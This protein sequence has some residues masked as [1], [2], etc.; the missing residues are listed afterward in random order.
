MMLTFSIIVRMLQYSFTISLGFPS[1]LGL[2]VAS[3]IALTFL[4]RY[5]YLARYT[6]LKEPALPPPSPPLLTNHLSPL[7]TVGLSDNRHRSS[8]YHNYLDDFLSAIRIFGYLEK[9]VFHEL[10]RHLQ[11]RILAAG[12]TLEIGGGDFWC[13]VEGKVQV[14]SYICSLPYLLSSVSQFAPS[15]D[16][17][18]S[19]PPSPDPF[20]ASES[21]SFNGYHL[22]NEVSTGGTLS[23]LFSILS[24][25][26]EDIKLAWSPLDEEA[27]KEED[28]RA[29][30][31]MTANS[32]DSDLLSA[33]SSRNKARADSDVSQ[34]G[35]DMM[36]RRRVA[37]PDTM[38]YASEE[39]VRLRSSSANTRQSTLRQDS[40]SPPRETTARDGISSSFPATKSPSPVP[41][42]SG[43][44]VIRPA[45]SSP[46]LGGRT[47]ATARPP[48]IPDDD[49]PRKQQLKFPTG[50][51]AGSTALKGTIAR[52]KIDT[53]LA[54]IPAKAFKTLTKRYPKASGTVVQVVLERFS[55]VTFM[56]GG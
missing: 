25:F 56:T 47:P 40:R 24:L 12:E 51:S 30:V 17:F 36:G 46:R 28:E 41:E 39:S 45:A 31:S 15:S 8:S 22:L 49:S 52:A 6:Q 34:M 18:S 27:D 19:S 50:I 43:G 20:P 2:F 21:T 38:S 14:V 9:P 33:A 48:G 44:P 55:R 23:S 11:T 32:S 42:A 16:A 1:L 5:R 54:V 26:T 7:T 3:L 29:D 13:V 4:I 10:S 37:S 53:T 35:H